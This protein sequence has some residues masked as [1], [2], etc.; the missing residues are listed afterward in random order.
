MTLQEKAELII[1]D[2]KNEEGTNPI[3]I[4]KNIANKDYISIHGP[5]YAVRILKE[6]S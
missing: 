5:E 1:K 2:I 4:F 6:M 3:L